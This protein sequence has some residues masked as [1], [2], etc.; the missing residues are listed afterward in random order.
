M[1]SRHT[2]SILAALLYSTILLS[3]PVAAIDL[4]Y[5]PELDA[6]SSDESELQSTY[7]LNVNKLLPGERESNSINNTPSQLLLNNK[8][9]E[10][11]SSREGWIFKAPTLT[12]DKEPIFSDKRQSVKMSEQQMWEESGKNYDDNPLNQD[13]YR[14]NVEAEYTF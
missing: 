1:N 5:N 14:I 11:T 6:P 3:A 8:Q 7:Q 2:L 12:S 13:N 4:S 10:D 9:D